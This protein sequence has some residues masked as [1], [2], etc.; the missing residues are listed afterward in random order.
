MYMFWK[1]ITDFIQFA[2]RETILL[3]EKL[4]I[5][6]VESKSPNVT[7]INKILIYAQ[8]AIYKQYMMHLFQG[9]LYNSLKIWISFRNEILLD[10][11]SE[12]VTNMM[13]SFTW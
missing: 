4:L 12:I 13:K 9:H 6:G 11:V 1:K 8:Y 7:N 10:N 3:N 5:I 2:F